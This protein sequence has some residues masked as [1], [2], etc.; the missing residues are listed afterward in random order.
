MQ[1]P[2]VSLPTRLAVSLALALHELATN[3]AKYGSLASATGVVDIS[4]QLMSARLAPRL[5]LRWAETG[6]PPVKPPTR[7][8]FGTRL[9][10]RALSAEISGTVTLDYN[11]DGLVCTIDAAVESS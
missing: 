3:A 5:A 9:L 1:G 10:Q 2:R 4:W 7:Q 6:G 8:G 11:P